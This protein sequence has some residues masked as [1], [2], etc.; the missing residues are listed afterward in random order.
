M[1]LLTVIIRHWNM[2]NALGSGALKNSEKPAANT[3]FG[4]WT[5]TGR[6]SV[7]VRRPS[8]GSNCIKSAKRGLVGENTKTTCK[9]S[10]TEFVSAGGHHG[11]FRHSLTRTRPIFSRQVH[12]QTDAYI[13]HPASVASFLEC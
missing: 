8:F 5:G 3:G 13:T 2:C 11:T 6:L 9:M 1:A 10:M 12:R 4:G 7:D